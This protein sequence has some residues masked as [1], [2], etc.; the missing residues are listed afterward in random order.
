M[1]SSE[2]SASASGLKFLPGCRL[3]R[4]M[5]DFIRSPRIRTFSIVAAW[6]ICFVAP[7]AA[8]ASVG[9]GLASSSALDHGFAALYNL[10]F[11]GAQRDFAAWQ[12]QHPDDPMGPVSE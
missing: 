12:K 11:A 2:P 1:N 5:W 6:C 7:L 9:P 8:T 4:Y 10:D 3:H